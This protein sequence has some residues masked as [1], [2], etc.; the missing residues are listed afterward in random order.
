MA[1]KGNQAELNQGYT[2]EIHAGGNPVYRFDAVP[3][4]PFDD[5]DAQ[6]YPAHIDGVCPL[7]REPSSHSPPQQ[8]MGAR[9]RPTALFTI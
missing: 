3:F 1:L 5:A 4:Q 2:E 6:Q 7:L 8:A 9:A